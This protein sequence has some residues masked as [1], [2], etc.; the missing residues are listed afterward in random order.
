LEIHITVNEQRRQS[1]QCSVRPFFAHM[2]L[3]D[4]FNPVADSF[5]FFLSYYCHNSRKTVINTALYVIV[6]LF[7]T[8]NRSQALFVHFD[9]TAQLKHII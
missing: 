8:A 1:A 9:K 5:H 2:V 4:S 7:G 6:F 3:P